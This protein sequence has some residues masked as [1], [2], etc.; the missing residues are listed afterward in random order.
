MMTSTTGEYLN[1]I[2]TGFNPDPSIVRVDKDYFLI[3][4]SFE[5]F[6]GVPIYHSTDLIKW[7]LI[8]H[9]LTRRSQLE[10]RTVEPSAGIWAPTL[11]YHG[12]RFYVITGKFD[13]YR[14]AQDVSCK[15]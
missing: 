10:L 15:N 1:P 4:S 13:R 12:G 11:R 3:T 5:Y 6:P 14:P 7:T 2:L 8:G 9:A